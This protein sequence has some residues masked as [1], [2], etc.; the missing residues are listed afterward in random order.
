MMEKIASDGS[1][2]CGDSIKFGIER[3]NMKKY[4]PDNKRLMERVLG[5]GVKRDPD[6][7]QLVPPGLAEPSIWIGN[8][9]TS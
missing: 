6:T 5:K 3:L 1:P 2:T 9:R 7:G 4:E 8:Q